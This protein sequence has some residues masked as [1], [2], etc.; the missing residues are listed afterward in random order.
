MDKPSETKPEGTKP[1]GG[2]PEGSKRDELKMKLKMRIGT[3]K[4]SR[5]SASAKN[6][7]LDKLKTGLDEI[8]K[9]TGMSSDDFLNKIKN[10][11]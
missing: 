4:M 8:L 2:K 6:E 3:S 7:K 5:M 11:L 9:S 10:K 1:E